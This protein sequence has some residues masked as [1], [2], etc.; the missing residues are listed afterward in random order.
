MLLLIKDAPV[1]VYLH[2]GYWQ[3]YG[4]TKDNSRYCVRPLV[5]NGFRVII[6]DYDICPMLTLEN[7]VERIQKAARTILEHASNVTAKKVIFAGHSAGAH[8][9]TYLFTQKFLQ[10]TPHAHLLKAFFL[11][12]GVYDLTELY[13]TSV[14]KD[15][16]FAINEKSAKDLSPV[17][18]SFAHLKNYDFE[19]RIYVGE[20]D[21]DTF[22]E[23]SQDLAAK[24][25]VDGANTVYRILY[26]FDHFNIVED[27]ALDWFYITK[28]IFATLNA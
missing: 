7:L 25:K 19:I 4:L 1:F 6:V 2:G 5:Q 27:L 16:I 22:I 26:D 24:L 8:L 13:E 28:D 12:S 15:N 3:D 21:T 17:Y 10:S 11:I 18:D 23:Q 9:C 14:N 20:Y